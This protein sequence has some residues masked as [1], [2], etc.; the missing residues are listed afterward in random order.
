[1]IDMNKIEVVVIKNEI[2]LNFVEN[3]NKK[4]VY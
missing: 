1:M 3:N 4:V 2:I